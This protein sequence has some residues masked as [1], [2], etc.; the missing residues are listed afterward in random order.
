MSTIDP[1]DPAPRPARKRPLAR[2]ITAATLAASLGTSLGVNVPG[3][4]AE[5]QAGKGADYQRLVELKAQQF[6]FFKLLEGIEADQTKLQGKIAAILAQSDQHK[7]ADQLKQL[8]PEEQAL[9]ERL[10]TVRASESKF[11][12]QIK[13]LGNPTGNAANELKLV[14]ADEFKLDPR[15]VRDEGSETKIQNEISGR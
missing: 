13:L 7:R 9:A 11:I 12:D 3:L 4:F 2:A 6:K 1:N 5:D 8:A 15:I 14:Q 10:R